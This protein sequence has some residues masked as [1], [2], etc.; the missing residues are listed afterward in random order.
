VPNNKLT[1]EFDIDWKTL[2]RDMQAKARSILRAGAERAKDR[3]VSAY[4][5]GPT[6]NLKAGV[7]VRSVSEGDAVVAYE[8]RSTA[9]H[10]HLYEFGTQ[11]PEWIKSTGQRPRP[12]FLPITGEERMRSTAEIIALVRGFGFQ[13]TGD[14]S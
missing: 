6:G 12:T 3:V 9:P 5:M 10:A 1:I 7:M 11:R 4:P 8:C 2:S 14:H 13:V